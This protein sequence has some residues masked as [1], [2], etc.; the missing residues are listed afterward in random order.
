MGTTMGILKIA[1]ALEPDRAEG[2]A[3]RTPFEQGVEEPAPLS[4]VAGALI[5]AVLW[6]YFIDIES[7]TFFF[8]ESRI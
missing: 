6:S 5:V 2:H 1:Q 8:M 7:K 4:S 3:Q